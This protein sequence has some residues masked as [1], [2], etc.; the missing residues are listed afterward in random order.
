MDTYQHGCSLCD[1][2]DLF[3]I[4]F[5]VGVKRRRRWRYSEKVRTFFWLRDDYLDLRMS[6]KLQNDAE[7]I[8]WCEQHDC[9]MQDDWIECPDDRTATLFM[10]KWCGS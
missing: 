10:L 9:N 3:L 8:A 7:L 2:R 5:K 4:M 6:S 1:Q